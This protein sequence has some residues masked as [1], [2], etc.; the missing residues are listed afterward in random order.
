[1]PKSGKLRAHAGL[2]AA[3]GGGVERPPTPPPAPSPKNLSNFT[4]KLR[5]FLI[6]GTNLKYKRCDG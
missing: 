4:T 3:V 5:H 1:M 2:A 6:P